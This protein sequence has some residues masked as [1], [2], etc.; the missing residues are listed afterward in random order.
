MGDLNALE[1]LFQIINSSLS[2]IES[3]LSQEEL[4]DRFADENLQRV[5]A[6]FFFILEVNF[7]QGQ[8]TPPA[9]VKCRSKVVKIVHMYT[10]KF[11]ED[12]GAYVNEF[13]SRIW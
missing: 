11:N 4:P 7:P 2:L 1:T 8:Q 5:S 13:F 9:L 3:F 10:F 12:F 6:I